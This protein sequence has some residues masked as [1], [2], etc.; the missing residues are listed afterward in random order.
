MIEFFTHTQI[1][2][3]EEKTGLNAS[4]NVQLHYKSES[5]LTCQIQFICILRL[6]IPIHGF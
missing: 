6:K 3:L 5:Y 4:L 2:V 1:Q